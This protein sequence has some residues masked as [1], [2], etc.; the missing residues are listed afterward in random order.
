MCIQCIIVQAVEAVF[1]FISD[2]SGVEMGSADSGT[3][4]VESSES[5]T[6]N[7]AVDETPVEI[8]ANGVANSDLVADVGD[9]DSTVEV[10]LPETSEGSDMSV[11]SSDSVLFDQ[12]VDSSEGNKSLGK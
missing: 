5:S 8:L 12:L 3:T 2:S 7:I 1:D 11:A 9:L 10:D 4:Q 6:A